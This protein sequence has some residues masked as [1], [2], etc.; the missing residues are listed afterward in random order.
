VIAHWLGFGIFVAIL[1]CG[2]Q[3]N[4]LVRQLDRL[5]G[6]EREKATTLKQLDVSMASMTPN[7]EDGE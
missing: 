7:V 3:I 1:Y 2:S 4:L 6:I 5:A